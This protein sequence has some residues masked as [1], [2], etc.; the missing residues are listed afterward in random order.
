MAVSAIYILSSSP[1]K[2][3]DSREEI[4]FAPDSVSQKIN[5]IRISITAVEVPL[6]VSILSQIASTFR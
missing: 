3:T 5:A 6:P 2:K 1:L 4:L